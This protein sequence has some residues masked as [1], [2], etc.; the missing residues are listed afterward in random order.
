MA[1]GGEQGD[2]GGMASGDQAAVDWAD[3]A[4]EVTEE[5]GQQLGVVG[6]ARPFAVAE[7]RPVD[8]DQAGER[9]SISLAAFQQGLAEGLPFA[10]AG[11]RA[12]G[13]QQ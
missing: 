13:R 11:D 7:A 8:A 10:A 3:L 4:P 1:L 5:A 12:Q 2:G 9:T 6:Q